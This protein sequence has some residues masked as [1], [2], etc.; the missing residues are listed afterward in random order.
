MII[1]ASRR[2]DIPAFYSEWFMNRIRE[3]HLF[4]QNPFNA[5]QIRRVDLSPDN[6]DVI[7][8]WTKNPQPI[9]RYL[10][11]LDD[12][13]YRYYFQFTVTAHPKLLE[14]CVPPVSELL[15]AFKALSKKIGAEK[16]VW[17][18]DPIVL[19]DVTP[20]HAVIKKF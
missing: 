19:S 20:E 15:A 9:V 13:G 11:E 7:V 3:G 10:D 1:S 16:V 17:R 4:V 8:F 14:P 18:F 5:Y 6:I 2:T 12:R